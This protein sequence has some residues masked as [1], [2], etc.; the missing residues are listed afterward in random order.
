VGQNL[1][2]GDHIEPN[3]DPQIT[4]NTNIENSYLLKASLSF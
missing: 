4:R 3:Q 2:N 1:F